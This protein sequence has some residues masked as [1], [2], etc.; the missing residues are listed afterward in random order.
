[1]DI[2]Q[3]I[4]AVI[5]SI[6]WPLVIVYLLYL[7]RHQL[8]ALAERLQEISLPGGGGAKFREEVREVQSKLETLAD[9]GTNAELTINNSPRRSRPKDRIYD[10]FGDLEKKLSIM[11][12]ELPLDKRRQPA[13]F[14]FYD[15]REFKEFYPLYEAY[16]RIRELSSVAVF[17]DDKALS[18]QDVKGFDELC[19]RFIEA[20]RSQLDRYKDDKLK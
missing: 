19:N 10:R 11:I 4:S 8:N 2:L 7:L 14:I 1:M 20:F 3:F 16:Q 13:D 17:A 12:S 6:V 9:H 18:D 5:G 15:L